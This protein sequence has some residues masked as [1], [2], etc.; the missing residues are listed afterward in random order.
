MFLAHLEKKKQIEVEYKDISFDSFVGFNDEYPVM[1]RRIPWYLTIIPTDKE[2][3]LVSLGRSK[4]VNY[5]TRTMTFSLVPDQSQYR[6]NFNTPVLDEN[7]G[8]FVEDTSTGETFFRSFNYTYNADKVK[9]EVQPY[10]SGSEPLPRRKPASRELFEA[11]REAASEGSEFVDRNQSFISWGS[12]YSRMSRQK[13]KELLLI[14]TQNFPE[15]RSKLLLGKIS[16]SA[17]INSEFKKVSNV[18]D[19]GL[20]NATKYKAPDVSKTKLDG[21]FLEETPEL[22]P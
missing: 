3:N 18:T 8:D 4:L 13:K 16:D 22:L 1:P 11:M 14:E 20:T 21:D 15:F 7:R 2:Q 12:I 9:E 6:Q 5:N 19:Q 17:T 10:K